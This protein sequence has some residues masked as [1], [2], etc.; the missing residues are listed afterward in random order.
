M[1]FTELHRT[2][3]WVLPNPWD[4]G[5]AKLLAAD[6]HVALATTSSGYS[7]SAGRDD[8]ADTLDQLVEHVRAVCAAVDVPV[9]VDS[10]RCFDDVAETVERLAEAGAAGIS[11]EDY[12]PFTDDTDPLAVSVERLTLAVTA[13]EPHGV[14]VTARADQYFHGQPDFDEVLS[15]LTAFRDA[16]ADCLY[17]PGLVNLEEV[18]EVV[19]LGL[20]VDV[21]SF[22]RCP[23]V[24]E[25]ASAGVR[26]I[27]TGGGLTWAA[28][29]AALRAA[30]EL[31]GPGTNGY[32]AAGLT[33]AQRAALG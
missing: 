32:L 33:P 4:V 11:I 6:G 30:D 14:I 13:A 20:P 3:T 23:T 27:S 5:S 18:A 25:L 24:P 10:E 19:A 15:R 2:G 29:A 9:N 16:G 21:L 26:R 28:Y 1:R 22:P 7:A 12:N 31:R 8:G 17:A